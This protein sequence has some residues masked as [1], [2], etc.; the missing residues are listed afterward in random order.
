[1]DKENVAY[2]HNIILISHKKKNKILS[3]AAGW[4]ELEVLMLN[5]IS[6]HRKTN[7]AYSDSYVGAKIVNLMEVESRVVMARGW[8]WMK[9]GKAEEKFVKEYKNTHRSKE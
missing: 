7:I 8:G 5:E 6:Q 4:M 9:E 3:F 2:I 1:M